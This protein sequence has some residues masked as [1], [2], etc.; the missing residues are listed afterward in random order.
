M[1][2][3]R[4]GFCD[5]AV[6]SCKELVSLDMGSMSSLTDLL[7]AGVGL[8]RPLQTIYGSG[9]PGWLKFQSG[10]SEKDSDSLRVHLTSFETQ[11]P[12]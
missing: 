9:P 10:P 3:L 12:L 1:Y 8:A 4:V 6:K 2:K 5:R 11:R 7:K